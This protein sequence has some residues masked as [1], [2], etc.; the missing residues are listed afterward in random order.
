MKKE[1]LPR[2]WNGLLVEIRKATQVKAYTPEERLAI[3]HRIFDGRGGTEESWKEFCDYCREQKDKKER[4]FWNRKYFSYRELTSPG[5]DVALGTKQNPFFKRR[6]WKKPNKRFAPVVSE[7]PVLQE[8]KPT[9]EIHQQ[10]EMVG[11]LPR[12][13]RYYP[14]RGAVTLIHL[15]ECVVVSQELSQAESLG[16]V[17]DNRGI[18]GDLKNQHI[19]KVETKLRKNKRIE[20]KKRERFERTKAGNA[21]RIGTG[22]AKIATEQRL[23]R[24][25]KYKREEEQSKKEKETTET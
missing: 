3:A 18:S 25:E 7:S 15:T 21:R 2:F 12:G 9:I 8:K 16:K 19:G 13:T 17:L 5:H 4:S 23:V 14:K 24:M 10:I 22:L 11:I 20:K 6:D 1:D